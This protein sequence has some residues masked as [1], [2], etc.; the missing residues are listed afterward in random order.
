MRLAQ[1]PISALAKHA[2]WIPVEPDAA[3]VSGLQAL[4]RG[5]CPPHL[6]QKVLQWLI[7]TSRNG[8]ALYFPGDAGRRDTDYALGRAFLGEQIV[9]FLR[10][11]LRG[12]S[13]HG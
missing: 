2:P 7:D 9:T 3:V 1:E 12:D 8:G 13:E 4:R 5:D 6:Q 10:M 11:K